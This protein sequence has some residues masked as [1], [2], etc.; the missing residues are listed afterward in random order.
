MRQFAI[1]V[2][3]LNDTYMNGG[4]YFYLITLI[5]TCRK[6]LRGLDD[7]RSHIYLHGKKSSVLNET[8]KIF[9]FLS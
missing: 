2:R 3:S 6:F 1:I 4:E 8:R 7:G 9:E 5:F